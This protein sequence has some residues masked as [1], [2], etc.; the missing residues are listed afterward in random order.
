LEEYE[1]LGAFYIGKHYDLAEKHTTDRFVLYDSKDLVTHGVCVGMTGSG[2]TGLCMAILEEAAIDRIP[3]IVIDPKGDLANLLLTFPELRGE[4]F[5]PWITEED[6]AKKGLSHAE[7]AAHQAEI[8]RKGLS[9]WNQGSERIR[10]LRDTAD[11][12]IYTPGSNAGIPM[13]IMKSFSAPDSSILADEEI[14]Q[15][16]ISTTVSGL[17]GLL[18]IQS[19]PLRGREHLLLAQIMNVAWGA[20]KDLDLPSLI[21]SIQTPPFSKVGVLD[22]ET[23]YPSK[24]RFDLVLA[25]NGLL[26]SPSFRL[27]TSGEPLDIA[28]ILHT[29]K[30]KP[31]VSIFSIAHLTDSERMFFVSTLL[32]QLVGWMRTQTG[33]NSLRALLYMDEI[34]GYFPP[35]ANPPSKKPMLTLLK[36]ARAFGLGILLA[37]QNPVDLDYRGLSN[38]G[39]W[40]IGRLQ[41]ERDKER[42]LDGLEGVATSSGQTFD[43]QNIDRLISGLTQRVFF[44]NNTHEDEPEVFQTRWVMSYMRG[45]I[46]R[47]QIKI[48]MNDKK[49]ASPASPSQTTVASA[50][51]SAGQRPS[52]PPEIVQ[53]FMPLRAPINAQPVHYK[54]LILG[55]ARIAF[56]DRK[57][58]VDTSQDVTVI[59]FVTDNVIPVSW[60]DAKVI[61]FPVSS[62][63]KSPHD[64]SQYSQLPSKA[65]DAKSY[66]DWGWDFVT[67]L[68]ENKGLVLFKSPATGT[69]SKPHESERDFRIRV[70]QGNRERRD[71]NIDKIRKKYAARI[72]SL[73]ER[74]RKAQQAVE[75]E[76]EQAKHQRTQTALS[77]G[78]TILTA[79]L[80]RKA[81]SSSSLS[82]GMTA[83]RG[84]G[85]T[86]NARKDVERASETVD[87]LQ[88]QLDSLENEIREEI[89]GMEM[90]FDAL[91]ESLEMIKIRPD[92]SN[93]SVRLFALTW[94]PFRQDSDGSLVPA[95]Q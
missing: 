40:F 22:L 94:A 93:I 83:M 18:G 27:W 23:F 51:L 65:A 46:T 7:Y 58:Q 43:R 81:V 41:T 21:Q 44:M 17:L 29:P 72:A 79:F 2:K 14:L 47:D 60:E 90:K 3:C 1:K 63:E 61:E 37:T 95:W 34:F 89:S 5:A 59:T 78:T 6:A 32:N 67:W 84:V 49:T 77:F 8:W 16:R 74:I 71:E 85:R 48:L 31:K 4:D 68:L 45:P 12:V 50:S 56:S 80:G 20:G 73:Q 76:R 64:N 15:E 52:L 13:S 36:Q 88:L 62:L 66:A 11:F 30:G 10:K 42:L 91:K 70:D 53:Y 75:R 92:R 26:A 38:T 82:R 87:A 57:Y 33:T 28:N 35:V 55:H 86:M 25:L 19:D 39:T 69:F 54:P 24:E 9:D